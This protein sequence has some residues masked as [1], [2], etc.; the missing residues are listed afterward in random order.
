MRTGVLAALAV[1][2]V[3]A[4]A[5]WLLPEGGPAL[6]ASGAVRLPK[7]RGVPEV[8]SLPRPPDG[9]GDGPTLPGS[10]PATRSPLFTQALPEAA[11][12]PPDAATLAALLDDLRDDDVRW[13]A[14]T[15]THRLRSLLRGSASRAATEAALLGALGSLDFQQRYFA[16]LVLWS[17]DPPCV[18]PRL[19]RVSVDVLCGGRLVG[20]PQ[21]LG[22]LRSHLAAPINRAV[23]FLLEHAEAAEPFLLPVVRQQRDEEARFL[24]A[25]V[26]ARGGRTHLADSLVPALIPRLQ[27]NRVDQDAQMAMN[28]L[29]SLGDRALWW[30]QRDHPRDDQH[31]TCRTLVMERLRAGRDLPTE[32]AAALNVVTRTRHDPLRGWRF[33]WFRG[34]QY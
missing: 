15:A 1:A 11:Q 4:L 32:R 8:V 22:A 26:L 16:A 23:A 5:V 3:L 10:L 33:R 27:D 9:P 24:A 30:L 12:A 6:A 20:S 14:A 13:N 2:I 31:S 25:F 17:A 18:D 7:G 19:L 29:V 34:R 21:H 28:A